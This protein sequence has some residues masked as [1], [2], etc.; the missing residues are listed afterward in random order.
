M[1]DYI[2]WYTDTT[3]ISLYIDG[4]SDF[5]IFP[6]M[7]VYVANIVLFSFVSAI[8]FSESTFPG[9]RHSQQDKCLDQ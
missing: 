9:Y 2:N 8:S 6:L 1:L 7:V 3:S 4:V 5:S